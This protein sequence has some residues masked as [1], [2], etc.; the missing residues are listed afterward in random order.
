M[1]RFVVGLAAGAV[2]FGL[3]SWGGSSKVEARTQYLKAFT[4]TYEKVKEQATTVKCG[5]CHGEKGKNKKT[6]S[7]YGKSLKEALGKKNE[8]DMAAINAALAKVGAMECGDGKT[9]ADLLK[10]G[11]LPPLAE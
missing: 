5:V 10:A 4:A 8:K 2:V 7:A 9:Y 3:G 1:N 6:V 11:Q